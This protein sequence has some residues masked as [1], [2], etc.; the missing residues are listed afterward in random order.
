M[1][2]TEI[3]LRRFSVVSVRPFDEIVGRLTSTIGHPD[4]D[5]FHSAIGEARTIA[6]LEV[7]VHGAVGPSGLMGSPV[8]TPAKWCGTK[9]TDA[10]QISFAS[11]S[12]IR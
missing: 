9:E 7:A 6:D 10:G 12:V 2:K 3:P 11:L 4:M 5:A 8:L 1:P